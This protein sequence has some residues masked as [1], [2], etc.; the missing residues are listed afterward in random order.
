MALVLRDRVKE[1]TSTSG[2]G[3]ITLLGPVQGFQG[4]ST[5][6]D[7]N[8]TYYTI[9]AISEWEVGIGTY[10]AGI[11]TRDTVL[12]SSD[13]GAKV[14]FST[15][16][17]DVF[18]TLPSAKAIVS[19]AVPLAFAF[20]TTAPN[21]TVNVASLTS[22]VA[23]TNG[24]LALVA[25]GNGAVVA[26]IPTG[27]LAGGNKRGQRAVDFQMIRLN[28]VEVASGENAVL[29]G[30]YA[31]KSTALQ[32]F[33]GGGA[34]NYAT[35]QRSAVMGG[36]SNAANGVASAIVGGL[37][38]TTSNL[39]AFIGGGRYNVVS[40]DYSGTICGYE[41]TTSGT[42]AFTGGGRS[43]TNSAEYATVA[44]GRT[45]TASSGYTFIGGGNNNTTSGV[46]AVVSGGS[47]NTASRGYA[48][49]GGGSGN[50]ATGSSS[51]DYYATVAGGNNNNASAKSSTIGGGEQ[52]AA[53]GIGS[54]ISG[55]TLN[56][57]SDTYSTVAGGISNTA[58][59]SRSVIV[60]GANNAANSRLSTIV[61]GSYGTTRGI[62]GYAVFPSHDNPIDTALGVSQSGLLILGRQTTNNSSLRLR[63]NALSGSTNNQLILADNSGVY[64]R[65]TVIANV[66]GGGDTKSW[67]F[68]GQIKRGANAAA[69]TLTGST[70][71]SPYGD[72][73]ASTWSVSLSA[74]TTNGCL[75]VTVA[76]QISTQ[77]RWVCRIESTEVTY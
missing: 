20:N 75:A 61:G 69:T 51:T 44:G 2:T 6:G 68:D 18:C 3:S 11:L 35:Q 7:G 25:K 66:T 73:G 72:A 53:S 50:T 21:D 49:V 54:V 28:A 62:I 76:G 55:G 63:S 46:N 57:V 15:G 34:Y 29:V 56:T 60:G 74:D 23:S 65:G 39:G 52:N 48:T 19:D 70:I 10:S 30:G 42:Y 4:F 17:K 9:V 8:T 45:N 33:V 43:N 24:D 67:T 38:N 47:Y 64:F 40:G 37:E 36:A 22:A 14:G 1:T 41:N 16:I 31:N 13:G 26:Q 71:S 12:A 58:S 32:T 77:I 59:G 27:T 5:I